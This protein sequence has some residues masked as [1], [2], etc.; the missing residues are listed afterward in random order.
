MKKFYSAI[1][2]TLLSIL[3]SSCTLGI[4]TI[5]PTTYFAP[6]PT[7]TPVPTEE[8]IPTATP[9]P[10]LATTQTAT[11]EPTPTPVA[12]SAPTPT[13]VS[14]RLKVNVSAGSTL[15]LRSTPSTAD[16]SNVIGSLP[17][18]TVVELVQANAAKGWHKVRTADGTVGFLHTDF[19]VNANADEPI[20]PLPTPTTA[21]IPD[22]IQGFIYTPTASGPLSGF[23]IGINPGHQLKGD[24]TREPSA[25]GSTQTKAKCATGTSGVSTGIAESVV[26]LS[27]GLKL[28]DAL[29]EQGATVIMCRI[30]QNVNVSNSQRARL[31]NRHNADLVINL[32]CNGADNAPQVHGVLMCLYDKGEYKNENLAA[33]KCIVN[34][35]V[36]STGAHRMEDLYMYD[37]SSFNWSTQ[38]TVLIEMGFMTN[39]EEDVKL[40]TPSYQDKMVTG[41]VNGTLDYF[42]GRTPLNP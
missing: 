1:A 8:F 27:V 17:N 13:P 10:T 15:R 18:G 36:K 24:Y 19:L 34:A 21:G 37:L 38:P 12:T 11:A 23:I 9:S 40:S 4:S 22:E 2:I 26:T 20:T 32:H 16:N 7:A 35:F 29:L 3:L 6:M 41:M 5:P 14:S 25:P 31:F 28:R 30:E 33:S 42:D 39:A